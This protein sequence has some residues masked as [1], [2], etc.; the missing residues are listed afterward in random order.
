MMYESLKLKVLIPYRVL[1]EENSILKVVAETAEGS[2]GILPNRLDCVA[3]LCP[4]ILAYEDLHKQEHFVAL[5]EGI[6]VKAADQV[7]VSVRNAIASDHLEEL[8]ETVEHQFRAEG[9]EEKNLKA[10][11]ARLEVD[12]V[13]RLASIRKG[14]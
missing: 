2:F 5:D 7:I 3:A 13:R 8:H 9:E 12:F 11:L 4:G 6:L 14:N 10:A 1:L